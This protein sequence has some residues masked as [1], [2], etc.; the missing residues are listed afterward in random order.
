[1]CWISNDCPPPNQ[2]ESNILYEEAQK[3]VMKLQKRN[4]AGVDD[5]VVKMIT[6]AKENKGG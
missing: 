4:V 5:I 1:M 2:Q 3:A 6:L